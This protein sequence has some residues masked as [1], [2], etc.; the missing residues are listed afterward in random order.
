VITA[1]GASRPPGIRAGTLGGRNAAA[2]GEPIEPT[3]HAAT[4]MGGRLVLHVDAAHRDAAEARR[5]LSIVADRIGRW[6]ARLTRHSD[7]SELA[8]LNADPN[9]EVLVG[10][11]L[12]AALRAGQRATEQA[13]G[14]V[15]ITL[16]DARLAAEGLRAEGSAS[17]SSPAPTPGSRAFD[18]SLLHER[19]GAALV[20]RPAGLR[21]DLDGIGKGWIADRALGLLASWPSAVVDADG[22]LAVRAA[23]GRM[24]EIA[25]DDPRAPV[26]SIATLRLA[27]PA[28]VPARWGVATSGTSI[29]R[30][31]VKGRPSHHLIDPRTGRPA[32]TDVVQATVIAGSALRAEALAKAAVIAGSGEGFALLERARVVGAVILTERDE[33]LALPQTLALLGS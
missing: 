1:A 27:A 25:V 19:R 30:W 5:N 18:W 28:S 4:S 29:H 10:P 6:A 14:L 33:T 32:V 20:R 23:P 31:T 9:E 15:D 2:T 13:E 11:T 7:V 24:W 16:L 17:E 22:D 12:A 26:A 21:F 8:T 3:T